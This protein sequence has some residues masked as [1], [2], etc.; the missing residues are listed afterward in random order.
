MKKVE[1][2]RANTYSV[3]NL[4]VHQR[5]VQIEKVLLVYSEP[6]CF[7]KVKETFTIVNDDTVDDF[8]VKLVYKIIV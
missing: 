2:K 3:E 4:N 7:D 6:V 1:K 5:F 8:T